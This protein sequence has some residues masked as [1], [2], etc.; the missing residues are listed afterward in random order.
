MASGNLRRNPGSH[1]PAL[2][3]SWC[4]QD[5]KLGY[6]SRCAGAGVCGLGIHIEGYMEAEFDVILC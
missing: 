2:D 4:N 5:A 1:C 6:R 3:C